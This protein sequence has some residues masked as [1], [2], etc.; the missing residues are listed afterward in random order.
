M[1]QSTR[2]PKRLL[3]AFFTAIFSIGYL[4]A[5]LGWYFSPLTWWPLNIFSIGF[6]YL[7][8]VNLLVATWWL[9][10]N[11]KIAVAITLL[12]FTGYAP[13]YNTFS[14]GREKPFLPAKKTGQLRVMQWNAMELPGMHK[15]WQKDKDERKAFETFMHQYNPDVIC[16]QDYADHLG[17]RLE[18]NEKFL[19]D[20]LGYPYRLFAKSSVSIHVFGKTLVGTAIFSKIPFIGTGILPYSKREIPEYILWADI[21]FEGK[22]LRLVTTHFR[23]INLF[24]YKTYQPGKLPYFLQQDS[25]IVMS[26]NPFIKIRHYKAEHAL[27]AKE[28]RS[29]LDTCRVPV[30]VCADLNTVPASYIYRQ[31]KG[32]LTDGFIGS[33]TGLGATYNY[34]LPNLRID[35]LLNDRKLKSTQWKHFTNGF[36]DH[37]HLVADLAWK[38]Q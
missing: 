21:L 12:L 10:K 37:D 28:V 16:I 7:L 11:R 35:Y 29:F 38:Q 1:K 6:P 24:G 8:L 33:K 14:I 26:T 30:V 17:R 22:P 4:L 5:V 15:G 34:L 13:A 23:S 25:S 3:P 27:Q 31:V 36:F 32:N 19:K 2:F 9:R 18:L 20:T